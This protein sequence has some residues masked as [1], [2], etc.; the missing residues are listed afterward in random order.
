LPVP[1]AVSLSKPPDLSTYAD[2]EVA[3]RENPATGYEYII[4]VLNKRCGVLGRLVALELADDGRNTQR[5]VNQSNR[6]AHC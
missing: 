5:A 1:K 4:D 3:V 2:G 6:P